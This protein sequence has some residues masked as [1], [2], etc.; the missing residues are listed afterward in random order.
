M[1]NSARFTNVD[2]SQFDWFNR[3]DTDV[4]LDVGQGESVVVTGISPSCQGPQRR[5][6]LDL[7]VGPGTEI[8]AELVQ[9]I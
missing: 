6:L 2:F 1:A 7:G 8:T 9:L 5:R 3:I 4:L